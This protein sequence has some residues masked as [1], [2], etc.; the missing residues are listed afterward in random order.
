MVCIEIFTALSLA[1]QPIPDGQAMQH[2]PNMQYREP[3]QLV[4]VMQYGPKGFLPSNLEQ[5]VE[6]G[7][8]SPDIIEENY[9]KRFKDVFIEG[10][11]YEVFKDA[12]LAFNAKKY[13]LARKLFESVFEYHPEV[14]YIEPEKSNIVIF[15]ALDGIGQASLRLKD[16]DKAL[17]KYNGIIN[18]FQKKEYD[19]VVGINLPYGGMGLRY[20]I[21]TRILLT[22]IPFLQ[23]Y[24][25]FDLKEGTPT[26]K[27][28]AKNIIKSMNETLK[29]FKLPK[30]FSDN[31]DRVMNELK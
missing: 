3:A 4:Q 18:L 16:Y 2:R 30:F 14:E 15:S 29:Y 12:L 13:E 22:S 17:E 9:S 8:I 28:L 31:I 21:Y 20:D 10:G 24:E 23:K 6:I 5:I 7:D 1:G 19:W 27:I 25:L 26:D 11:Y